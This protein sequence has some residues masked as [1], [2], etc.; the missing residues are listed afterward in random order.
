MIDELVREPLNDTAS[1]LST[2]PH[3]RWRRDKNAAA[4]TS[5]G[6]LCA[7]VVGLEEI[8]PARIERGGAD[9]VCAVADG[10]TQGVRRDPLPVALWQAQCERGEKIAHLDIG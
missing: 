9:R 6:Q 8:R 4:A 3:I 7:A 5:P 10:S 1:D 2:W